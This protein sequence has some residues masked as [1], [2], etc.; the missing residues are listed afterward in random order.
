MAA[1]QTAIVILPV[2]RAGATARDLRWAVYARRDAIPGADR[3][4][5]WYAAHP[6]PFPDAR[7]ATS[8]G[9]HLAGF[10]AAWR[11]GRLWTHSRVRFRN[12]RWAQRADF[13]SV[14]DGSWSGVR[15]VI[16]RRN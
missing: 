9:L 6:C 2:E 7:R 1:S 15:P 3:P 8:S 16:L 4:Q 10:P 14:F 12:C 13:S 11:E 5:A